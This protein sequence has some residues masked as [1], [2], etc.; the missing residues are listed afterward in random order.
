MRGGDTEDRI[1]L[2]IFFEMFTYNC[3]AIA[4]M[5]KHDF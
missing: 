2:Y 4:V 1:N 5:V 3:S